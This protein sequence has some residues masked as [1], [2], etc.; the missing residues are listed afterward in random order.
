MRT[1]CWLRKPLGKIFILS[2]LIVPSAR[3]QED[4]PGPVSKGAPS[5]LTARAEKTLRLQVLLDRAHFSP[6]EI[7]AAMG[8]NTRRALAAYRR[9]HGRD[10][11]EDGRPIVGDYTLVAEDLAGPFQP[12][13][14]DMMEKAALPALGYLSA[15]EGLAEKFHASPAL[16]LQLNPGAEFER[17]G[18]TVRVPD[19]VRAA[20][21]KVEAV[22][23]DQS[24]S[25][26]LVFGEG[27]TLL[28]RYPATLGSE[29]DP[30]PLGEWKVNGVRKSPTF[31]Y[32]PDLFWDADPSHAKAT[33][34]PGPNNPVGLVWVDLSKEHYGIHGTAEPRTVGKTQSHGCIRLTN[35]DALELAN[36]VTPGMPAVLRE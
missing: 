6:G 30:L 29:R 27:S 19:T 13:P 25:S 7:D 11:A 8:S 24:D 1:A 5:A 22:E 2:S 10:P 4:P 17:L 35:W 21:P 26:V 20:L 12:V 9:T 33:L 36:A 34:A 14:E 32:N 31:H 16:L 18:S 15:L 3:A 28:A 23:V